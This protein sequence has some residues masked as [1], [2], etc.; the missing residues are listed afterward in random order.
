MANR[1]SAFLPQRACKYS[2]YLLN[3]NHTVGRNPEMNRALPDIAILCWDRKVLLADEPFLRAWGFTLSDCGPDGFSM[4]E[5]WRADR[6]V[7]RWILKNDA[8]FVELKEVKRGPFTPRLLKRIV[9]FTRIHYCAA[10]ERKITLREFDQLCS[11]SSAGLKK[12][13]AKA[14]E[15]HG[16]DAVLSASVL[17]DELIGSLITYVEA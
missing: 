8:S 1:F 16:G 9:N 14:I 13:L 11:R 15:K 5:P 17:R 10:T 7:L 4:T 3:L 12:P 6:R 2:S